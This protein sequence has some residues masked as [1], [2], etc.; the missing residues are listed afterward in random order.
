MM[1]ILKLCCL[2]LSLMMLAPFSSSGSS[3]YGD[4]SGA[5]ITVDINGNITN[6]LAETSVAL[7]DQ[8]TEN[9]VFSLADEQTFLTETGQPQIPFQVI[10]LL[11]PPDADLSSVTAKI[12]ADY[13]TIEG[14]CDVAPTPPLGSWD[15]QGNEIVI[16]PTKANIVDGYD[17]DIYSAKEYWPPVEAKIINVGQLRAYKLAEVAVP[18]FR[19]NPVTYQLQKLQSADIDVLADQDPSVKA[20]DINV[21]ALNNPAADRIMDLAA[22]YK[23]AASAYGY[24]PATKA[25]NLDLNGYVIITTN[26]IKNSSTM[27]AAF[28]ADKEAHGFQVAVITETQYGSGSGD[29]AAN[30][31]RTFL[32]NNYQNPNFG[33]GGILYALLIGDPRTTSSS[34]PMKMCGEDFPT[35]YFYGELTSNWD[36]DGDGIYG[37]S[38]DTTDKYFEVYVGRIPYYGTISETDAILQKLIDY[39]NETD[40]AWRRNA[41]LPMVPLDDSTQGYQC[42]EQIKYNL[43]EPQA[44]PSDRIYHAN[45]GL[46]PAPEYLLEDHSPADVW[47]DGIYGMVIWQTHGNTTFA[48]EVISSGSQTDALNNDFPSVVYQGSC[49]TGHPETTN[50]LGYCILKN[51]GISTVAASRNG[52][53]WV[54]QTNFTNTNSVGGIGYQYAKHLANSKTVGQAIWDTKETLSFWQQNY[55][56]YNLYGDPSITPMP[57][58]PDM[59]ATPTHGATFSMTFG[60]KVSDSGTIQLA[61]NSSAAISWTA[62]TDG[63]EWYS[64]SADS[65]TIAASST[66]NVTV[67]LDPDAVSDLSVGDHVSSITFTDTTNGTTFNREVSIHILPKKKIA[68]WPFES[69]SGTTAYDLSGN[70]YDGVVTNT[71]FATATTTGV[72]GNAFNFDGSDDHIA[73]DD[74]SEDM[75]GL[76]ISVWLNAGNWS[77]NRRVIQKGADSGEYRLLAER[78]KFVFE[79]GSSRL[80]LSEMPAT[81]QWVHVVAVYDGSQM[82]LYYDR[83]LKGTLA[84]TGTVPSSSATLFIGTKNATSGSTDRYIGMMDELQI[85]N[86]AKSEAEIASLYSGIVDPEPVYPYD[87]SGGIYLSE[88]L[89]WSMSA[90][91]VS[92]NVY[93]SN[94]YNNIVNA[95]THSAEFKASQTETNFNPGALKANSYYYWRVDQVYADG[96]VTTGPVWKFATGNGFGA[97]T[98]EVWI[99]ISGGA[100]S[101]L[102]SNA[103]YPDSPYMTDYINSFKAPALPD[104]ISDNYGQRIHGF[105][106]PPVDGQYTF[107]IASDDS[108]E[109]WI[110]QPYAMSSPVKIC[111]LSGAA[112]AQ[113]W[114][115]NSSQISNAFTLQGGRPYYI[116]A[117]HKE[118]SI[119]DHVEVGYKG[120]GMSSFEIIPGEY[121]MPYS[122]DYCWGPAFTT[123]HITCPVAGD[124]VE[125]YASVAGA[126]LPN[127]AIQTVSY[128]K[129]AGPEWL[130]V[131]ADGTLTGCPSVSDLGVNNFEVAAVDQNGQASI[132]YLTINVIDA[133][134]GQQGIAD[135]GGF[136]KN[137]MIGS[138][139]D[140][141]CLRADLTGD[142]AVTVPD[143]EVLAANWLTDTTSASSLVAYFSFEDGLVDESGNGYVAAPLGDVYAV[144]VAESELRGS[145]VV[146]FDGVDDCLQV[147]GYKVISDT[148]STGFTTMAWVKTIAPAGQFSTILSFGGD[149]AG[150]KFAVIQNSDAKLAL[151]AMGGYLNTSAS[152]NDGSWHHVAFVLDELASP[153]LSD[154][155]VFLDGNKIAAVPSTDIALNITSGQ[156]LMIGALSISGFPRA[157]FKGSIDEVKVFARPLAAAE[158]RQ[159]VSADIQIHYSA[160]GVD[161]CCKDASIYL[162]DGVSGNPPVLA[163]DS[164]DVV[165]DFDGSN[166][167]SVA[168]YKGPLGDQART[169]MMKVKTSASAMGVITSWGSNANGENFM[170][171]VQADG[172]IWAGTLGGFVNTTVSIND[173]QWHHLAITLGGDEPTVSDIAVY[174]D[175]NKKAASVNGDLSIDT[176]AGTDLAIGSILYNGNNSA[177]FNGRLDE[178]RIYDRALSADEVNSDYQKQLCQ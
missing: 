86:Y 70:G 115:S 58:K 120:P 63:A 110:A 45:Y 109:L 127:Y 100:V 35:D 102:T 137:W 20:A 173:G 55:F 52:L 103:D 133:Y 16:W 15:E 66:V 67:T 145:A 60:G 85:F 101:Y 89:Q 162:R 80:E 152:I 72:F 136:A 82:K 3:A 139:P 57:A 36:A 29:T 17:M 38:E 158:I 123:D 113:Q 131:A 167:I 95:N 121:L 79:I 93:F 150:T 92:N 135:F 112:N 9:A 68:Y 6:Y 83:V 31:V 19:Y 48:G 44:I 178:F 153:M 134:S 156:D 2:I 56:V 128:S 111:Y 122:A 160:K 91:A 69:T 147:D 53:Y 166:Y 177:M 176:I 151:A 116:K 64:I 155:K 14:T 12:T 54:G 126:A 107:A 159:M 78:S 26:A 51:G 105:F 94:S 129:S 142:G 5:A 30:N 50:N 61:N 1:R 97:L 90:S 74:L 132:A 174:I 28:V 49:L 169:V 81:G 108:S 10:R 24:D 114:T 34:V 157:F 37:E 170:V 118:G 62:A 148:G 23:D 8:D 47:A 130:E 161:D 96:T 77:S 88:K 7:N 117:L 124:G 143:L 42:G 71:D 25:P 59:T 168:D 46:N 104:E 13:S 18:L 175:G 87:G 41:L 39:N 11:L 27:L 32:Q 76:T 149:A 164:C 141:N 43:L 106:V 140:L 171:R 4:T 154:V 33:N 165:M 138:C 75:S 99:N 125:Y 65:G 172:T 119:G 146:E 40:T 21:A 84:R 144:S 163:T 98:R 73:V 22:N